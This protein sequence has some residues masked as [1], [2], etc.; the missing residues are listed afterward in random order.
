MAVIPILRIII[1]NPRLIAFIAFRFGANHLFVTIHF[2]RGPFPANIFPFVV[3]KHLSI[4][5][6]TGGTTTNKRMSGM[7]P[8]R[9]DIR[10]VS[11]LFTT[12]NGA[13]TNPDG[14][15]AHNLVIVVATGLVRVVCFA[16]AAG[17]RT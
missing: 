13:F 6:A 15:L 1:L 7:E 4:T 2:P 16:I 9:Q 12:T 11:G 14:N 8:P 10:R 3:P 5:V 17:S